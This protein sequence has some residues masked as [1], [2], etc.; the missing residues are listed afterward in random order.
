LELELKLIADVGLIGYP[1]AGKSSFLAAATRANPKVGNY[2]FTTLQPNLGV[3]EAQGRTLILA[4]LPGIIEGASRGA[5][6]GLEFLRHAERTSVLLHIVDG[7]ADDPVGDYRSVEA[8]LLAYGHSLPEKPRLLVVNKSDRPEMQSRW[9][10]LQHA[11]MSMGIEAM[12]ASALTGEGVEEALEAAA[13]RLRPVKSEV[14]R[15][16]A[17]DGQEEVVFRPEPV[18]W[19]VEKED[20]GAFRVHHRRLERLAAMVEPDSRG[21]VGWFRDRLARLGVGSSL[22]RV[23][24]R[25]GDIIRV[26]GLEF[27]W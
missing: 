12:V 17:G 27:E 4:D 6:L 18:G 5:G 2:P 16:A 22:K 15:S 26:G 19:R 14:P 13:G 25:E 1:N 23:G 10:E 3:A 7:A 8:E 9:S 20:D 11:F 21:A 24:A